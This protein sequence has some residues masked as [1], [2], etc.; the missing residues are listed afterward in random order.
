MTQII[1]DLVA[2][3]VDVCES[4]MK[5]LRLCGRHTFNHSFDE[6]QAKAPD[7]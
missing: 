3:L 2:S 7:S 1:Q 5:S 4:N 6:K